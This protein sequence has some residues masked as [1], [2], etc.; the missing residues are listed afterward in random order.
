MADACGRGRAGAGENVNVNVNVN[1][2]GACQLNF[3]HNF[4]GL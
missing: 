1:D 3:F 2:V 4:V